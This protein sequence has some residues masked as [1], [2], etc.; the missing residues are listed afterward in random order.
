MYSTPYSWNFLF[1][2]PR[3]FV[4][5]R[6]KLLRNFLKGPPLPYEGRIIYPANPFITVKFGTPSRIAYSVFQDGE[7]SL[8][9]SKAGSLKDEMIFK[10]AFLWDIS[11]VNQD[12]QE[13]LIIS[14]GN[15]L[16][17]SETISNPLI[18]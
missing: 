18:F 17:L 5:W 6:I 3:K 14:F 9:V 16:K 2:N 12:G 10:N 7:W 8:H 11:D 4:L 13:E 15:F 1:S